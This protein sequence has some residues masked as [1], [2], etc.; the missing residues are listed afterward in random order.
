MRENVKVGLP[1]PH[2]FPGLITSA[3]QEFIKGARAVL[4]YSGMSLEECIELE[5]DAVRAI[6]FSTTPLLL[7]LNCVWAQK[8]TQ[9]PLRFCSNS[10][11]SFLH[12]VQAGSVQ[13]LTKKQK[14]T[15]ICIERSLNPDYLFN[16][17]KSL[18]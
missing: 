11:L 15:D 13:Q 10:F 8:P 1:F 17:P 12:T 4:L 6:Q 3:T 7:R 14:R 9:Q 2:Q 18:W 5:L 16:G